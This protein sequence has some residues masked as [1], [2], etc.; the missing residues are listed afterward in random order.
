MRIRG[1]DQRAARIGRHVNLIFSYVHPIK[2]Q[3]SLGPFE[4]IRLGSDGIRTT[5]GNVIAAYRNHQWKVEGL[6]YFRADCTD[7]VA[8]HFERSKERSGMYGPYERFSAVNGLAYGDDRVIAFLDSKVNEWLY[9]DT[10][11]HWPVM[12]VSDMTSSR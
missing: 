1:D 7:R 6:D 2:S 11:Y 9:Y 4:R 5:A 12:I 8:L 10:G 3:R